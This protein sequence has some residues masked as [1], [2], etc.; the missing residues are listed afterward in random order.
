MNS[1]VKNKHQFHIQKMMDVHGGIKK[2]KLLDHFKGSEGKFWK[3][4]ASG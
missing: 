1:D 3:D 2:H 4:K